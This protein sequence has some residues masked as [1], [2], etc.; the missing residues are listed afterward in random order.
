MTDH[1]YP[2]QDPNQFAFGD[3]EWKRILA[4]KMM[5]NSTIT[6]ATSPPPPDW[7]CV[8]FGNPNVKGWST[9]FRPP[10]GLEPNWFHRKMQELCFGVKWKKVK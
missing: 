5:A 8:L 4:E 10:S 1:R 3:E 9:V 2:D 7:E 6:F